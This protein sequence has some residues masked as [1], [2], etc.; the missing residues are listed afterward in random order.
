MCINKERGRRT[1]NQT[2]TICNNQISV[3]EKQWKEH[4]RQTDDKRQ[5][6]IDATW[7]ITTVFVLHLIDSK[8]NSEK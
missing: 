3:R 1:E 2:K 4:T 8:T 6:A 7:M 5:L